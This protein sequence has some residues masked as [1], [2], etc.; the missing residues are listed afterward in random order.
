MKFLKDNIKKDG[1]IITG[2]IDGKRKNITI[3]RLKPIEIRVQKSQSPKLQESA[4]GKIQNAL[5]DIRAVVEIQK[6]R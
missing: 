4:R 6:Q 2:D 3:A 5:Q 1:K